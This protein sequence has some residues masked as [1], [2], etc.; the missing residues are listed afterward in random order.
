MPAFFRRARALV[1][2]SSFEGTSNAILQAG[3]YGAAVV[4][5]EVD[6]DGMFHRTGC[7]L[8]AGGDRDRLAEHVRTVWSDRAAALSLARRMRQYLQRYHDLDGRIAEL[9][10]FLRGLGV[11]PAVRETTPLRRA[12]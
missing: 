8:V 6:P 1:N 12:G 10:A 5:L 4:S 3:K 11:A 2:T 7:A 9:E